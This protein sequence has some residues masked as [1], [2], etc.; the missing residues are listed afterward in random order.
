VRVTVSRLAPAEAPALAAAIAAALHP[1]GP[2]R[3]G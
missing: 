3:S 1:P 2:V